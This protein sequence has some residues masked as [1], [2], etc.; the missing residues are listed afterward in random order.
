MFGIQ[1]TAK[2]WDLG[3]AVPAGPVILGVI[4]AIGGGLVRD[5]LAGRSNLLM[6]PELYAVPILLGCCLFQLILAYLPEYRL[7]GS[8]LCI[9]LVFGIRAA[10]I[11]WNL[12]VPKWARTTHNGSS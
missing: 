9:L 12:E 4:T 8:I 3:F 11:R 2:A 5:V 1:G 7:P 10:A 6:R